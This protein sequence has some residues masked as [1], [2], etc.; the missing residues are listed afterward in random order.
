MHSRKIPGYLEKLID[1][2]VWP[3][4]YGQSLI[5]QTFNP[6]VSSENVQKFAEDET[7]ICLSI[8]P[9]HTVEKEVKWSKD[10]GFWDEFGALDQINPSLALII[11]DFGL[12]SDSPIILDYSR[13]LINPPVLRLK[14]AKYLNGIPQGTN[15]WVQGAKDFKEFAEILDIRL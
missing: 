6:I 1:G 11:G 2:G 4:S 5:E 10:N 12:G 14:W 3:T 8:P 13:D 9:F 7:I 15:Q